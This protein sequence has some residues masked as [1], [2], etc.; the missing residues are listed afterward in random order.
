MGGSLA[1]MRCYCVMR[2]AR[3]SEL[4]AMSSCLY[5]SKSCNGLG[6]VGRSMSDVV[7]IVCHLL[8][9]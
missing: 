9:I 8:A 3:L 4:V 7:S 6:P 5:E 1:V 2:A